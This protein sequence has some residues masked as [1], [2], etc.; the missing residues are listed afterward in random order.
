[1]TSRP[2]P[3]G[4]GAFFL[5]LPLAGAGRALGGEAAES[6]QR[7]RVMRYAQDTCGTEAERLWARYPNYAV[8]RHPASGKRHAAVPD[9]PKDRLG[10]A[11][12]GWA[13]LPNVKCSPVLTGSPLSG[14]GFLPAI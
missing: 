9:V 11:G 10:L 4:L 7:E 6:A 13:D 5:R 1:M 2:W 12:E 3:F 14:R 8:F